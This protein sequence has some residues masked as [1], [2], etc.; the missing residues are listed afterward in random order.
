MPELKSP[1]NQKRNILF[2]LFSVLA[3]L[4]VMISQLLLY[5]YPMDPSSFI[6]WSLFLGTAGVAFFLWSRARR[7]KSHET[8]KTRR[9]RIPPSLPLIAA[10]VLLTVM[11]SVVMVLFQQFSRTNFIPVLTLWLGAA[12]CYLSAFL[13]SLRTPNRSDVRA[14]IHDHWKECAGMGLITAAAAAMRF[15]Q[16]GNIPRVINGDEGWIGKIA[17]TTTALPYANPFSLWENFGALYLQGINW[18]F[19]FFGTNP[20]A[21]RLL[22]AVAGT[23]AVPALYLLARQIAGKRAAFIAA[24][25]LAISHTHINFSRTAGVGYIQDTW[26]VPLE[27][28]LFLSGLEKRKLWRTALAGIILGMHFSIYLTPQIFVAVLLVFSIL[29]A[30]FYRRKYP[31]IIR[32]MLPLWGGLAVMILPE[33]VFAAS[34]PNEFFARLNTDGTFQSGWLAKQMAETGQNVIQVLGGRVLHTFLSLIYYPSIDF[35]G[36]LIP[37][38]SLFSSILFLIGLGISLWKTRTIDFLLLNG[39]FWGGIVAIGIFSIPES[40]DTYRV[41]MILPAAMLMASVGLDEILESFGWGWNRRKI[42][43]AAATTFLLANLLVFNQ[44]VYFVDFAGQCRYGGDMQTRFA[45][46]LGNYMKTLPRETTVYLLSDDIYSYGTH[47]SADFL[48]DQK[49]VINFPGPVDTIP[50]GSNDVII[51]SPNRLTELAAW[52]HDRTGGNLVYIYDC[53]NPI[54]SWYR[55]P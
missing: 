2:I 54:L 23:L 26:L 11:T 7:A 40:A 10:A 21:L 14:W 46:Y 38:L 50:F 45:S 19:K 53:D 18:A 5:S 44:W 1:K 12:G 3:V 8:S 42:A 36:S 17:E 51:A 20:F 37:V 39:Y 47:A 52:A 4:L 15:Y 29:V 6:P 25:M 24:I 41:L 30:I 43:Y 16:L 55:V 22:P 27:L 13:P 34:H 28:Y 35:Y 9:W 32:A 49:T 48:S 33:A 31:G